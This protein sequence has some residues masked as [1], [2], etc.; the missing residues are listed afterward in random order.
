[1]SALFAQGIAARH[2]PSGFCD[3][4]RQTLDGTAI[5]SRAILPR[6]RL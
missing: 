6:V 1:M 5:P 2:Y 3:T 4:M